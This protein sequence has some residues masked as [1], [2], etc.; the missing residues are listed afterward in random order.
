LSYEPKLRRARCEC[1]PC[2]SL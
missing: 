1:L 2:H